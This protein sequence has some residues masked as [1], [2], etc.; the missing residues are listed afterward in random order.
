VVRIY[1][2]LPWG[3]FDK[4]LAPYNAAA[5]ERVAR[6]YASGPISSRFNVIASIVLAIFMLIVACGIFAVTAKS[7]YLE[8]HGVEAP[9]KIA[10]VSFHTDYRHTKWKKLHYEFT[11]GPGAAIKGQLDRPVRELTNLPGGDRL[12]VLYWDRFPSVNAP[13]GVES[14][15]GINMFLAGIFLLGCM[16]FA[17][18]A[19]R[20]VRW[21]NRLVAASTS[22]GEG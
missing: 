15:A 12:T 21:R 3:A 18:L 16:N 20:F 8:A 9:G 5:F 14:N 1:Q 19:W 13:R 7:L 4:L 10:D 22:R 6:R 17:S 11:A 2:G